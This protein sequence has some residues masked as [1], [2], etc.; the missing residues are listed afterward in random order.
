MISSDR[1]QHKDGHKAISW[2]AGREELYKTIII[3]IIQ[4]QNASETINCHLYAF[5]SIIKL[6]SYVMSE[7]DVNGPGT[8]IMR[9]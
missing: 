4:R 1:K 9:G 6:A 8:C 2:Y 3:Y 5:G 7:G